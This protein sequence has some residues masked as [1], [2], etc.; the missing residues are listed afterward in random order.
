MRAISVADTT[1]AE[2]QCKREERALASDGLKLA[3]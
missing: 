3:F 1:R 2:R